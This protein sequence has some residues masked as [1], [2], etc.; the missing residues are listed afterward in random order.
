MAQP[1]WKEGLTYPLTADMPY[2][3]G[4][5]RVLVHDGA[6]D[7]MFFLNDTTIAALGNRL[8]VGW[9]NS[10]DAE[11][12][13]SSLIRGRFSDDGGETWREPFRVV[14]EAGF[15]EEHYVPP[16][17]FAH[18][19]RMYAIVTR[20]GRKS[21]RVAEDSLDLYGAPVDGTHDNWPKL[22]VV[23]PAGVVCTAAPVLMDNGSYIAGAW[24]S[25][26][27][28]T[29]S[30]AVALISQGMDIEKPW[31]CSF[32]YN[33]LVPGLPS[34]RC[35]EVGLI[36][37]GADITAYVRNDEGK[38][39]DPTGGR[40]FFFTSADYGE[41]WGARQDN[42]M[43][44][45]NSKIWGG[46]LSNGKR[47]IVYND[48]RGF[49]VRTL[50][51]L[52]VAEPGSREYTKVYKL[53]EDGIPEFGGRGHNWFYPSAIEHDGRLHVACTMEEKNRVR[54]VAVAS[55]PVEGL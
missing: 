4:M 52:A 19:G 49:F 38:V 20:S 1:I 26:R 25:K 15:D 40:P 39:G 42:P 24:M 37:D 16:N 43:P 50:L 3:R 2:P 11:I 35:A 14:G 21:M 36:V 7:L 6:K 33:P 22:S 12:C 18:Q 17:F 29:P 44:I 30:V 31:R 8:F 47:Y 23:A 55:V 41:T 9:Y 48:D 13:G 32:L 45:G 28:A 51:L 27:N 46:K 10:T 34:I 54:S 53:F 5:R